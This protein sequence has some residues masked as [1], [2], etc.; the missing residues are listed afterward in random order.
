[1]FGRIARAAFLVTV[2]VGVLLPLSAS[3][4]IPDTSR[5][6]LLPSG[7]QNQN[8]SIQ[9]VSI[10]DDGS[11]VVFTTRLMSPV[12]YSRYNVM[13]RRVASNETTLLSSTPDGLPPKYKDS[14]DGGISPDGST[15]A[16]ASTAE[17]VPGAPS[18]W[19]G[20]AWQMYVRDIASGQIRG[21]STTSGGVWG[22]GTCGHPSLSKTGRWVAF[23]SFANNLVSGD[24]NGEGDVFVKDM[25][26][27]ALELISQST[28][29]GRGNQRSWDPAMSD[30]GRY[31]AFASYASNLVSGDTNGT[32][33][34]FLR[35][36]VARTTIRVSV[37][38]KGVQGNS[39]S[40]KPEISGNGR[41]VSYT[42]IAYNLVP[43]DT[44]GY[45]DI[46]LYDRVNRS[47]TRASVGNYGRQS[48]G[49]SW[50]SFMNYDAR[51]IAFESA[52]TNLSPTDANRQKLDIY[53]RDRVG[54]TTW[55]TSVSAAGQQGL[56]NS[57]WSVLNSNGGWVA[58]VSESTNLVTGD[59]ND[60]TDIFL[61][62]ALLRPASLTLRSAD[63]VIS[64]GSKVTL[65]G[66]LFGLVSSLPGKTVKL[67]SSTDQKSWTYVASRT[68]GSGGS[69]S[70][71]IKPSRSLYYRVV[72]SGGGGLSQGGSPTIRQWVSG[73]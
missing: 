38:S 18:A 52:A 21:A 69:F 36:R 53:I 50:Y 40:D 5:I 25:S 34:I 54:G 33:D 57:R 45:K 68:T 30:D 31:V 41:W 10:S 2:T 32:W 56:G 71:N 35:D 73:H 70:F 24:T 62:R 42:S 47:T 7:R 23:Y 3:A 58:F 6:S 1:M 20:A 60:A 27:G 14:R 29:G 44:N 9:P 46:F 67:Q 28:G 49:S 51:Y 22:N 55:R 4:A 59:T 43:K 66:K 63:T 72:Y 64:Y 13:L 61:R 65:S 16:F 26:T 15:A 19:Q 39:L 12:D 48:N 37:S 17:L 11:L 8:G